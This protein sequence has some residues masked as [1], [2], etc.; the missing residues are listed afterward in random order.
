MT[1]LSKRLPPLGTL[2]VFDAAFRLRSF[3]KAADECALSQASVSRQM[4]V[5]EENVGTRLF[6]RMRHSVEPT[7]AGETF[8]HSVRQTLLQLADSAS[9]LRSQADG[10]KNF[11]IYSDI[12]I[13][14]SILSPLLGQLQ[15]K[16]P[17]VKFHIQSTYEPIEQT[18]APFDIGFQVGVR[19]SDLFDVEPIGDDLVYPVCSPDFAST[20]GVNPTPAELATLPLL[21]LDVKDKDWPDWRKFLA[22]FR[23]REP[24]PIEGLVFS[25]YQIILDVAE[26]GE[27]IALGWQRSVQKRVAEG[28][29]VRLSDMEIHQPNGICVYRRKNAQATT[30]TTSI[31]DEVRS[32][33]IQIHPAKE[34]ESI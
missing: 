26:R 11:R 33:I 14:S 8:A 13:A 27:G 21:H 28:K 18:S 2:V 10:Q 5:L 29:L 31:I 30:L 16:H 24:A 20:H 12:S 6:T 3:S 4:R 7:T 25:S 15:R 22:T 1:D 9:E 17:D 19:A 23:I 32:N 34:F